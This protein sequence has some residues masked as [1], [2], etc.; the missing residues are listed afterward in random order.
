[1]KKE[2]VIAACNRDYSW[3]DFI[4]DDVRVTVYKKGDSELK[5]NEVLI[6]PNLGRDVHTFFYHLYNNYDNLA[7]VT[8]FSQD[9]PFDHVANYTSLINGNNLL[10]D[11]YAH[12]FN[13]GCWFFCT[14]YGVLNCDKNGSPH[15]PGLNLEG[16]WK[17]LFD[18]PCPDSFQFTPSGHFAITKEH[19][20]KTSKSQY[21]KI[22]DILESQ[23]TSPWEIERLEPYIFSL[24]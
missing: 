14:Q 24:I 8:F 3:I 16:M 1:M 5:D 4:N 2:L 9:Y 13:E 19:A 22:L 17:Q 11:A 10:W 12:Q 6:E 21:R 23:P 15:H 18:L 7:D 20:R